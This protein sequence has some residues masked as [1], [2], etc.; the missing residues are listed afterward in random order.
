MSETKKNA[1]QQSDVVPKV[2][3]A[4][5]QQADN[6]RSEITDKLDASR[7]RATAEQGPAPLTGNLLRWWVPA[8]GSFAVII[9]AFLVVNT[10]DLSAPSVPN[11]EQ[12]MLLE[13]VLTNSDL[14]LMEED[15]EFY[16]WLAE[17][18]S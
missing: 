6:L 8:T 2:T 14:E 12:E 5:D 13:F 11:D 18:E 9:F 16:L 3:H 7:F 15:L 17:Q 4:L 1:E 10:V